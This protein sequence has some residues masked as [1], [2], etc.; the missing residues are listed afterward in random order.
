[1]FSKQDVSTKGESTLRGKEQKKLRADLTRQFPVLEGDEA[2][3]QQLFGSAKATVTLRKLAQGG[4]RA[5]LCCFDGTV[6]ALDLHGN[7][8]YLVP[9]LPALWRAPRLLPA[10]LVPPEVS[11]FLWRGADLF[12]PGVRGVEGCSEPLRKG[13]LAAVRVFGNPLPI[14]VGELCCDIDPAAASARSDGTALRVL[15]AYGDKLWDYCG[16]TRPNAGFADGRVGPLPGFA[17][18]AIAPHPA[19]AAAAHADPAAAPCDAS[20]PSDVPGEERGG[21]AAAAGPPSESGSEGG[22]GAEVDRDMDDLMRRCFLQA[23]R[24]RLKRDR[25]LPVTV[26]ELYSRHLRPCRPAGSSV[27]VKLSSYRRLVPFFAAL[28]ED[29]LLTLN[30]KGPGEPRVTAI[31]HGHRDIRGHEVWELTA[32]AAEQ[33]SQPSS[34][35]L[36]VQARVMYRC[37]A[38]TSF[39]ISPEQQGAD[40][41]LEQC[42]GALTEWITQQGLLQDGGK[43]LLNRQV[44]LSPELAALVPKKAGDAQQAAQRSAADTLMLKVILDYYTQRLQRWWVITGGRL[45]KP[46]RFQGQPPLI[47]MQCEARRGHNVTVVGGLEAYGIKAEE[48][49][50]DVKRLLACTTSVS[51]VAKE[52]GETRYDLVVQGHRNESIAKRLHQAW[53]IPEEAIQHQGGKGMKEKKRDVIRQ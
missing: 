33:Q 32:E 11:S 1:M 34:G 23:A 24:T 47:R 20:E 27:D 9:M 44:R 31:N 42:H 7:Q 38:G 4:S 21:H 14:A 35:V 30:A 43:K 16:R 22:E 51:E 41:T 3:Q 25:D 45:E 48:L 29:G 8:S 49:G 18:P 37:R 36:P 26:G 19:P 17:D 2:L 6:L 28:A 5:Q 46:K 10:L 50:A 52:K 15:N 40:M 53:G 13:S 39:C 12:L